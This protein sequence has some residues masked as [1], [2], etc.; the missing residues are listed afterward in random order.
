MPF[1]G[2]A[3]G[4][5]ALHHVCVPPNTPRNLNPKPFS[6]YYLHRSPL[7]KGVLSGE[8]E[9]FPHFEELNNQNMMLVLE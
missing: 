8:G 5:Y 3:M 6:L 2:C 1:L 9:S 4:C 7:R